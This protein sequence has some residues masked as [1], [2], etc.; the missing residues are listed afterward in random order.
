[1]KIKNT[2]RFL[3]IVT[4]VIFGIL[5]IANLIVFSFVPPAGVYILSPLLFAVAVIAAAVLS[6]VIASN[7]RNLNKLNGDGEK[8]FGYYFKKIWIN[9]ILL[10]LINLA[11][12][13]GVGLFLNAIVGGIRY[14]MDYG[15]VRGA[16]LK[17]PL[18]II[19]L[20]VI[21][22]MFSQRGHYD[23]NRKIFNLH[24]KA[25]TVALSLL[26]IMPGAVR[27]SMHFTQIIQNIGGGNLQTA[28]SPHVDVWI[29]G[30]LRGM[31]R[32]P[33]FNI[34]PPAFTLLLTFAIQI[35]VALFAYNHAKEAFMKKRLNPA[36]FDP[37]EKC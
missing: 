34:I 21:Y 30:G 20:A 17:V 37:N 3:S 35:T 13:E 15:F 8:Q 25:L 14:N 2:K 9:I 33:N 27:D 10:F 1:M 16:V 5:F 4:G 7:Y 31:V 6:F 18:F 29:D 28:L 36:E 26:V 23:A 11:I 32:N 19:Y 24:L 22:S 12:S